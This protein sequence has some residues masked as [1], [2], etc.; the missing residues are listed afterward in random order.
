MPSAPLGARHDPDADEQQQAALLDRAAK[1]LDTAIGAYTE[2]AARFE[3][4]Q[5]YSVQSYALYNLGLA[6]K[7]R[8]DLYLDSYDDAAHGVPLYKQAAD[9]FARCSALSDR[10]DK[11]ARPDKDGYT[12]L[13]KRMRCFCDL[14]QGAVKDTLHELE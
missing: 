6:Q 12:G 10:P 9:T 4:M 7:A 1:L 13:Q 2:V 8:A 11:S 3:Q 14:E 5:N